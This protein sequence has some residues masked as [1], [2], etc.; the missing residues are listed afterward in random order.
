MV[1]KE[2]T[3]RAKGGIARSNALSPEKRQEIAKKA[4]AARWNSSSLS[5]T[6]HGILKIGE[7]EIGCFVLEDETRVISGRGMTSAIG[8]QGRGQGVARIIQHPT[9]KPFISKDLAVAIENPIWVKGF[10]PKG[11][12]GYEATTLLAVAESVLNARDEGVLKTEQEKRYA[13]YC[14]ALMRAF[15]KVGIIALVDEATGF[16]K[17]RKKDALAQ[18][19]EAFIAKELQPY[20]KTFP[21]EYYEELFRLR[22][23]SFPTDSVKRPPYFGILTNDIVYKRI[24][25]GVLDELKTL[26]PRSESGRHK[27]KLFQWLTDNKG[28][29]KLKD[30]LVSVVTIMKLSDNWHDFVAKINRLHPK[31]EATLPLPLE[32][33]GEKDDGVGL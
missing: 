6:H 25:P 33:E 14:D 22:G 7:L 32:Y 3:G 1:V 12:A 17:D 28:Y 4:A 8:M 18:I 16:Q 5:A 26:T 10:S 21:S 29:P 2:K 23:L 19:L 15:A 20:V 13:I 27:Q 24:A 30:H 31:Y 9:L 11:I